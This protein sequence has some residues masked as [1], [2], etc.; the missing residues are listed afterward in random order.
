[1]QFGQQARTNLNYWQGKN[2][3]LQPFGLN[4]FEI[5]STMSEKAGVY[6][7]TVSSCVF[8]S[9]FI[10]K[11]CN[12]KGQPVVEIKTPT[13]ISKDL[14]FAPNS[15]INVRSSFVLTGNLDAGENPEIIVSANT[16]ILG[17]VKYTGGTFSVEKGGSLL[18]GNY[19]FS[20]NSIHYQKTG[21]Y[22]RAQN[23]KSED[24]NIVIYKRSIVETGNLDLS[25]SNITIGVYTIVK[26]SG[27]L[28]I[29]NAHLI[30]DVSQSDLGSL[31]KVISYTCRSGEFLSIKQAP[32]TLICL[33]FT[34]TYREDGLYITS[35][36]VNEHVDCRRASHSMILTPALI[37]IFAVFTLF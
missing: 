24:S 15:I 17:N 13:H 6:V 3:A 19:S 31:N 23:I 22:L 34:P 26:L 33:S 9:Y 35:Q 37:L 29:N 36:V 16:N 12:E 14:T 7:P 2:I 5:K 11:V 1:M 21:S 28:N 32:S 8:P 18:I 30:L 20:K 27:C 4:Y 25:S 10:Q